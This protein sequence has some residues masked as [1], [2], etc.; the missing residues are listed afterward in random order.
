M[1]ILKL[2]DFKFPKIDT[3]PT[4]NMSIEFQAANIHNINVLIYNK[5]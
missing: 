3:I 1:T 4:Q 5:L 2:T